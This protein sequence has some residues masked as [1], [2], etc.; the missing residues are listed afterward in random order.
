M[1]K[2][3]IP[4]DFF[5]IIKID[6]IVEGVNQMT[7]NRL[8]KDMTYQEVSTEEELLEKMISREFY[9]LITGDLNEKVKEL[10]QTSLSDKELM[11]TELGSAGTVSILSELIYKIITLLKGQSKMDRKLESKIR[12]YNFKMKNGQILLYLRQLDY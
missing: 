7:K 10:L 2:H 3:F 5:Y 1:T 11:G 8:K 9:I 4:T 12:Q 6:K